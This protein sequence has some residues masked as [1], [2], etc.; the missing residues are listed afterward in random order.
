MEILYKP[1]KFYIANDL[2]FQSEKNKQ[3]FNGGYIFVDS[4]NDYFN[5]NYLEYDEKYGYS[6]I[7]SFSKSILN[8]SY[9]NENY[10]LYDYDKAII[11]IHVHVFYEVLF[12]EKISSKINLIKHPSNYKTHFYF[13]ERNIALSF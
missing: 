3:E 9:K 11:A 12:Y 2:I 8:I 1:Q 10:Q 5:G 6:S 7:N 13:L 4:W